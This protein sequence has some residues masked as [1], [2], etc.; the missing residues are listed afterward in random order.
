VLTV[1]VLIRWIVD[2]RREMAE[3]PIHE[4]GEHH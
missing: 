1:W 3:L 4:P 2:A